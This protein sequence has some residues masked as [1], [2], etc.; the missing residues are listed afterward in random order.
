M[1]AA[2]QQGRSIDLRPTRPIADNLSIEDPF[3]LYRDGTELNLQV[4]GV[5]GAL[6]LPKTDFFVVKEETALVRK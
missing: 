5:I 4:H 1:A 6:T 3:S 2:I